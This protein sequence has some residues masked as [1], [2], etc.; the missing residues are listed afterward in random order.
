MLNPRMTGWADLMGCLQL[1][2]EGWPPP[3]ELQELR[4]SHGGWAAAEPAEPT[5]WCAGAPGA[6]LAG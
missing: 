2:A 6:G 1:A 3:W 4:L 5:G